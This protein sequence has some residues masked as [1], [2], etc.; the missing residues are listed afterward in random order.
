MIEDLG[1]EIVQYVP[2]SADSE[3]KKPRRGVT[4]AAG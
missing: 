4:S 1:F 3:Q 2:G